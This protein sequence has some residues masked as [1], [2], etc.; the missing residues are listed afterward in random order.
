MRH[1]FAAAGILLAGALL[2]SVMAQGKRPLGHDDFDSWQ[3]ARVDAMSRSG[4]WSAYSVVP[5]EGDAT[6]CLR[7]NRKGRVIEIARG[8]HPAFTADGKWAV[9]LIS[10]FYADTRKAKID[11][12]KDFDLPQD[13]LAIID[14]TT[15]RVEKI[16]NVTDRKSVV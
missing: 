12:K 3:S 11:K 4:Q 6:L 7:D 9:A 1:T 14:L 15:A 13:S 8:H 5:Q 16:P 2:G 10:P